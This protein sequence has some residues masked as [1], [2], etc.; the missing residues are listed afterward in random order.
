[1]MRGSAVRIVSIADEAVDDAVSSMELVEPL[2][3]G[4]ELNASCPNVSWGRDRDNETHLRALVVA[5][6][7]RTDKPLFVKLPPFV[8]ATE[9][10]VVL[11]LARLSREAGAD[12]LT[13]SN[14]RLVADTRL[15]F[16]RGG[17]S[18]RAMWPHTART[19]SEVR[20]AIDGDMAIN[21]SGGVFTAADVLT[22]LDAGATTVQIYSAFVYGGPG[23]IGEITAGLAR[24]LRERAAHAGS[25]VLRQR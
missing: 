6:R 14:T 24:L 9:R 12:G 25:P 1:P 7:G 8:S 22:C 13:C 17:L 23:V 11:T 5:L 4:I 3:D 20:E 21:A 15:A 18:G 16:G 19:V 2:V 10:E